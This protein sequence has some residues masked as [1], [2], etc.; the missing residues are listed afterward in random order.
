V[1]EMRAPIP[2]RNRGALIYCL[3]SGENSLEDKRMCERLVAL[4]VTVLNRLSLETFGIE[5]G[6]KS[7]GAGGCL[8]C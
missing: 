1:T 7:G 6:G 4:T 3:A 5:H 8:S 2:Q